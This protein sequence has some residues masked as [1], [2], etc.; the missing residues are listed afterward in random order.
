VF[1][2]TPLCASTIEVGIK[3]HWVFTP[4]TYRAHSIL[5]NKLDDFGCREAALRGFCAS[6]FN[7]IDPQVHI[8]GNAVGVAV[9][10]AVPMGIAAASGR[11]RVAT[12]MNDSH[13]RSSRQGD[14]EKSGRSHPLPVLGRYP[15]H[16]WAGKWAGSGVRPP[17]CGA[18]WVRI[19][20]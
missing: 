12:N 13:S 7:F 19:G 11:A 18:K 14:H 10:V 17:P 4:D 1:H 6:R 20:G 2:S 16:F 8:P 15:Y 9:G 5:P 3:Y